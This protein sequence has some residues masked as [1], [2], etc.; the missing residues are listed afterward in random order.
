MVQ[1]KK[2][3]FKQNCNTHIPKKRINKFKINKLVD[4]KVAKVIL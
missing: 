1:K 4:V 2:L 3:T